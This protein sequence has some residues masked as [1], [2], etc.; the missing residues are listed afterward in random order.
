MSD[1]QDFAAV[2]VADLDRDAAA[3]ELAR[4]A[5][6]LTGAD[7]AYHRDDAPVMPDAEYDALKARNAAIEARF[8]ALVRADSPSGRVGGALAEGFGKVR[9][10][11]PMLSLENAFADEDIAEFDARIRRFLS[12]PPDAPLAYTAEPK[13]DGLSLSIR[14]EDGALVHAATRGDGETGENVTANIRTMADVPGTIDAPGVV[15]VRGEV[16]MAHDDFAALNA[17]AAETG[18]RPFA[19][20]RNAAAG[21]LR[22]LDPSITAARPLRFFAYAW[23]E[24]SAP[25][26]AT[27]MQTVNRLKSLGFPT[28]P[29]TG[30]CETPAELLSVYRRIEA[31]RATL[32]YDIDGVV[33]KINDLALQQRLGF[34]ST[35]P[36]WAIAHKFPAERAWTRLLAI[37]IQVGRTGALSPVAR[38]QPVTVGGVVVSNAT[39]HNADY[40]AG[41]TGEG[42]REGRDIRVGDWVEVYRAGDVIPKIRDVDLARRPDDAVPYIFPDHCPVCGSEVIREADDATHRCT[43][44][45]ACPA[46]AIERLIHF[47]GRSAFDIDG[48]GARQIEYFFADPDLPIRSPADI[49]RLRARDA[50]NLGKLANRDGYGDTSVTKLF[51]AIDQRRRIGLDRLIFALGIRHVG[52]VAARDLARHFASWPALAAAADTA[53]P[54]ALAHLAADQAE[55]V[56][57]A[58]AAAENRR[59]EVKKTRDAAWALAAPP[60]DAVDAWQDIRNVEGFGP[61]LA[62]SLVMTL[63]QPSERAIIDDLVSCLT[64]I[65]APPQ[66]SSASPVAG[67]TVV[68]TGKLER[69]SRDEAK[70][71]AAAL[72]AKVSESVSRKTDLVVAGP[73]AGS[74]AKDAEKYGVRMIGED[75]WLAL[76]GE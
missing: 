20:P 45:L 63:A 4:L 64:E 8:P 74:K 39:L 27:Q 70:A 52:E 31:Q 41:L 2:P 19:N 57:R 76:I 29:L 37:D 21:S 1:D 10:A 9:H 71:Q 73:G 38:L 14:Y 42:T 69:K 40:I 51:D 5:A 53:H 66:R 11:V 46:Q 35:T 49:F 24:L 43:G 60:Q 65:T 62:A 54:A 13:I 12:L 36:R 16:Y 56:E 32:G 22:Q 28:N 75:E 59:A 3:A 25:L 26:G 17:R 44:G 72:G 15:E 23:G 18:S 61:T 34:R 55:L 48:L 7:T 33:Y 6:V 47:V 50:A 67:M 58:A 30:I 68:F